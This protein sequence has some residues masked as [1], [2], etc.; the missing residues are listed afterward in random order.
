MAACGED[1]E[2]EGDPGEEERKRGRE[3]RERNR[4][5]LAA[6]IISF[7]RALSFVESTWQY[8]CLSIKL[9]SLTPEYYSVKY[10]A[11]C[12]GH[13]LPTCRSVRFRT[14]VHRHSSWHLPCRRARAHTFN[15]PSQS[16]LRLT[17]SRHH[18]NRELKTVFIFAIFDV[19][20]FSNSAF[21]SELSATLV[22][23]SR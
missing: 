9:K 1:V 7:F 16:A 6:R 2:E 13:S 22:G 5:S 3:D 8:H 19:I 14:S 17:S 11:G 10:P 4:R 23:R 21:E 15:L 18:F 12:A 20:L